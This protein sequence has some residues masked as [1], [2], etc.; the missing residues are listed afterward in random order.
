LGWGG[1]AKAGLGSTITVAA[2][3]EPTPTSLVTFM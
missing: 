1:A 2:K 3:V